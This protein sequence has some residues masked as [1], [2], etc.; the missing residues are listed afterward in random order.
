M[1]Y[2]CAMS[3]TPEASAPR[4]NFASSPLS[5]KKGK[6]HATF[7]EAFRRPR[8]VNNFHEKALY[9]TENNLA[10]VF[11]VPFPVVAAMPRYAF[12]SKR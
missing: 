5:A 3:V 4:K 10:S 12:A 9:N 2:N 11:L 7:K 6:N 8:P 1:A